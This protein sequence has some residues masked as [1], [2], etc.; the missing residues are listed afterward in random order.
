M[1]KYLKW[2]SLFFNKRIGEL[3]IEVRTYS[4]TSV[5][6]FDLIYVK[7]PIDSLIELNGFTNSYRE[8]RVVFFKEKPMFSKIGI[9][10]NVFSAFIY[11]T[12]RNQIYELAFQ[13]GKY[14]RF[15][16]DQKF[17]KI[18]FENLYKQWVD[19][20]FEKK[21]A[22][23]IL[24]YIEEEKVLGFVTYKVSENYANI[25]LFGTHEK[26]QGKGIG[27]KLIEAVEFELLKKDIKTLKIS[28]NHENVNACKFYENRGYS[29]L[30]KNNLNH[31]WKL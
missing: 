8:N 2:D 16:L 20:S 17:K 12:N 19:K 3:D 31:F 13:S 27:T 4:Q 7:S 5:E 26:Y 23:E 1:I 22:D 24:V 25:G 6:N 18:E 10:K 15:N 28:A 14:S 11:K 9:K 30:K 21:M 29:V